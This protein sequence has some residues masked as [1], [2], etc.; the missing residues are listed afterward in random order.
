MIAGRG[1]PQD[2]KCNLQSMYQENEASTPN[3]SPLQLGDKGAA[4]NMAFTMG[5][6]GP[7][8]R[9]K[10]KHLMRNAVKPLR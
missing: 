1:K 3:N 5:P 2:S 8:P 4:P 6:Q 7:I 10:Q 9:R